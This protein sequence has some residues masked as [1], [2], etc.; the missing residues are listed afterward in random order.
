[1]N[2]KHNESTS[3]PAH[4]YPGVPDSQSGQVGFRANFIVRSWTIW[5]LQSGPGKGFLLIKRNSVEFQQNRVVF[6]MFI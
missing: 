2:K 4:P 1:M 5:N 3:H 6:L